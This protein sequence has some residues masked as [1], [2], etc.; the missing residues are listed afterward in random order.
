V[1]LAVGVGDVSD[2][3]QRGERPLVHD[4]KVLSP[5][6]QDKE[7]DAGWRFE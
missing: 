7:K 2:V 3:A 6:R 4:A 1:L 5:L